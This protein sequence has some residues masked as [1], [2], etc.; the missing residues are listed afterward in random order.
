MLSTEEVFAA[1]VAEG[2]RRRCRRRRAWAVGTT[3]VVVVFAAAG[4]TGLH[5]PGPARRTTVSAASPLAP[6]TLILPAPLGGREVRVSSPLPSLPVE[7]SVWSDV[8]P[9]LAFVQKLATALG[10]G[11]R[12]VTTADG[13]A[14][15]GGHADLR[16]TPADGFLHWQ[17]QMGECR[18]GLC[19]PPDVRPIVAPPTVE[20]RD[21]PDHPPF[22]AAPVAAAAA[23]GI[24]TVLGGVTVP[25]LQ[26]APNEWWAGFQFTAGDVVVGG[27]GFQA[28]IQPDGSVRMAEGF[29]DR[30][31]RP[32]ASVRLVGID[33]GLRRLAA[34]TGVQSLGRAL[35]RAEVCTD[36][37]LV[38]TG[39]R[40]GWQLAAQGFVPGYLFSLDDGTERFVEA[41]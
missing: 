3:A 18:A 14:V 24:A 31:G 35:C 16:V 28:H 21:A 29:V 22:D 27:S 7:A 13:F 8:A 32:V 15:E 36:A 34:P 1:V 11:G 5:S 40:V 10:V 41:V 23:R 19:R 30:P 2:T 12:A 17:L 6:T 33:E 4:T 20:T 39:V 9:D 38:V 37:P 26:M 25:R